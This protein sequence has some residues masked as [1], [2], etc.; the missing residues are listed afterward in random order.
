[1]G[2]GVKIASI[3]DSVKKK[4]RLRSINQQVN[5]QCESQKDSLESLN[6][7]LSAAGEGQTELKIRHAEIVA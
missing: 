7:N 4:N 1:M 6:E 2:E 5:A 3:I